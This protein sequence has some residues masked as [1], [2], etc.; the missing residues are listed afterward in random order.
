MAVERAAEI[1]GTMRSDRPAFTS[2]DL[3]WPGLLV[4]G[5]DQPPGGARVPPLSA[6]LLVVNSAHPNFVALHPSGADAEYRWDAPHESV[7]LYLAPAALGEWT[8]ATRPEALAL[9]ESRLLDDPQLGKIATALAYEA[10]EGGLGGRAY[11]DGLRASLLRR[12]V[13]GV[14]GV[15]PRER[16]A[17]LGPQELRRVLD[18]IGNGE[19]DS[20]VAEIAR[21]VGLSEFHLMRAFRLSTG[22]TIHAYV[23]RRRVERAALRLRA[24]PSWAIGQIAQEVGFYD[25]AHLARHFRRIVGVTP[26]AYRRHAR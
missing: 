6:H 17:P 14:A 26:G 15:R 10:R 11:A 4:E 21:E 24:E 1:A 19:E 23:V 20:P 8:N 2:R 13:V 12:T 5:R 25:E 22:T 3:A 9:G 7:H 18:R 16:D